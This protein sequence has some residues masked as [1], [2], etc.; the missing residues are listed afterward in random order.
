MPE[1]DE[2]SSKLREIREAIPARFREPEPVAQGQDEPRAATAELE[3]KDSK[4]HVRITREV[5]R[6]L[7]TGLA[8]H[9]IVSA[10]TALRRAG[11][12]LGDTRLCEVPWGEVGQQLGSA[13]A[14]LDGQ[15]AL[16]LN[17]LFRSADDVFER[18][19]ACELA[20]DLAGAERWY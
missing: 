12:S 1:S 14:H 9:Q 17:E 15:L 7:A 3:E 6:L 18:G 2:M 8:L 16:P 11:R 4:A 13:L 19:E 10:A 5:G 20:G